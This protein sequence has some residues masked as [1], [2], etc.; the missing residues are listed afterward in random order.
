MNPEFSLNKNTGCHLKLLPFFKRQKAPAPAPGTSVNSPDRL[1]P[2][3]PTA[4]LGLQMPPCNKALST[5]MKALLSTT[6]L[7]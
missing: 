4:R 3:V 6:N 1:L 2:R 7:C 5:Q